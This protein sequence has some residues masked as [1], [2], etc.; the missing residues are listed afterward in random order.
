MITNGKKY[1]YLAVP[2]L[3][4]LLQGNSSNH[5]GDFSFLNCFNSYTSKNKL[6]EHEHRCNNNDGCRIEMPKWVE[7]NIKIQSRRKIVK[8]AINNLSWFREDNSNNNNDDDDD[9]NNNNNDNND[10]NNIED[11]YTEKKAKREHS[12]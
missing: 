8:S 7:K 11:S 3:S 6:K 1:H 5:E 10:N 12:D 9:N 4:G 2:N